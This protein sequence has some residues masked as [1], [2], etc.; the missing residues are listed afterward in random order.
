MSRLKK[1]RSASAANRGG[2]S[3][4]W[5]PPCSPLFRGKEREARVL[6]A[7]QLRQQ[8]QP[9]IAV[10]R[11]HSGLLLEIPRRQHGGIADAAIRSGRIEARGGQALLHLLYF[12]Q[13][14]R[15]LAV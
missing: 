10:R 2:L 7:P 3:S 15:A 6:P 14:G 13:G 1:G 5:S 8:L 11:H 12:R 9:E 4:L